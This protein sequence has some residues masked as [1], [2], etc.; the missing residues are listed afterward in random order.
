MES[1]P[2][3]AA[4]LFVSC[5]LL[6]IWVFVSP[7]LLLLAAL[8][9]PLYSLAVPDILETTARP[10]LTNANPTLA[11]TAV[12]ARME[13]TAI[14][15]TGLFVLPVVFLHLVSFLTVLLLFSL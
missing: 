12:L 2:T 15:A 10:T 1:N 6:S 14:F 13:S 5:L 11:R 8:F 9:V 7:H 4:G 3:F